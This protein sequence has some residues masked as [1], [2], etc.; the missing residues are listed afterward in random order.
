LRGEVPDPEA[1]LVGGLPL[2]SDP[3]VGAGSAV[4]EGA[5]SNNLRALDYSG[6]YLELKW[7]CK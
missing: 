5:S 6:V 4:L 2:V 7:A 3:E 1:I